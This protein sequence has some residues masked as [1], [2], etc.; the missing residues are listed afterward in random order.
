QNVRVLGIDQRSDQ[1]KSDPDVVKAITIEVT[2]EQAQK[3]TLA[4]TIGKLSLSLRDVA[5]VELA[6]VK[7]VSVKDLGIAEAIGTVEPKPDE[8]K[9]ERP[10]VKLVPMPQK[11]NLHSTAITRGTDR[12]E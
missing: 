12:Q 6:P 3:I 1:Q 4:A 11:A 2:T 9:P 5:N 10:V 7:P 8:R